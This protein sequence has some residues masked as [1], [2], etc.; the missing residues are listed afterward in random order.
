MHRATIAALIAVTVLAAPAAAK[1]DP[2]QVIMPEDP[3]RRATHEEWGFAEAVIH[4]DTVW[5]SGVVAR[6]N[7][8][9]TDQF[10]AFD[11]AFQEI[12]GILERAG[13]GWDDVIEITTY[14]TD[15]PAQIEAFDAVK[16]R[17]VHAPFPAW[18]AIDVDRLAPESGIAEIRVVAKRGK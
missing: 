1:R 12:A 18:T 3:E 5:L 7:P 6:L 2:A 17:Y 4:G 10:A 14:H 13:S 8:G 15:L 11:R 9:E 16:A